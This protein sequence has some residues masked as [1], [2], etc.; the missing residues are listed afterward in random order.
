MCGLTES[1]GVLMD[2]EPFLT[3]WRTQ[4]SCSAA[5]IRSYRSDLLQFHAFMRERS[6]TRIT[7]VDHTVINAYIGHMKKK[8]NP[9]F[10]RI[11]LSDAS[12]ARRLAALS[13]FFEYVRATRNSRM[14]NPLKDFV[15]KWKKND[16]PKPVDVEI[17]DLLM[18]GI[19]R[20]RD[21]VLISLFLATGLRLSEVCQLNRDTIQ[22]ESSE[23]AQGNEQV[24]GSGQVIGKGNKERTFFVDEE[25]LQLYAEYLSSRA[26]EHPAL[27]LSERSK[28]MSPR[29]V[30]Y[31]L[32]HWCRT[33]GLPHI[34]IHRLRHSFATRMANAHID[35]LI[36]MKLLGHSSYS[37][38]SRYSKLHDTTLAQG[39]FAAAEHLRGRSQ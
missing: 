19:T 25:T 39:Y 6:I 24:G 11:G 8:A 1:G 34:N 15:C 18:E 12:I 3:Q 23:D 22:I 36:L 26:D 7:Q 4:K 27:F 33:L 38:T 35:S 2:F 29:A 30:Q 10:G 5:T 9:R 32:T 20:T 37:M 31:T 21:R 14:H 17:L 13:S 28:R 16:Q